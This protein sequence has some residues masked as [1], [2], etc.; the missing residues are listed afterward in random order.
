MLGNLSLSK[1][2][3]LNYLSY[4][5]II[6]L[7]IIFIGLGFHVYNQF[8][9]KDTSKYVDNKE[10][11]RDDDPDRS[12]VLYFFYTTWCPYSTRAKIEWDDFKNS[13]GNSTVKGRNIIFKEV[14]CEKNQA[15]ADKFKVDGY[16]TIK[17]VTTT[18]TIDFDAKPTKTSLTEFLQQTL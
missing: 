1:L 5:S 3:S 18:N 8:I 12:V 2:G 14:D 6:V 13:I 15:I 7:L 9:K 16:P 4:I 17:L 10:F 11:I